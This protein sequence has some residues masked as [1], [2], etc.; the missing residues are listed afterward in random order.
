MKGTWGR[1]ETTRLILP[2]RWDYRRHWLRSTLQK[3]LDDEISWNS[4]LYRNKAPL[5]TS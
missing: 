5:K 4:I 3:Q 1:K 2:L